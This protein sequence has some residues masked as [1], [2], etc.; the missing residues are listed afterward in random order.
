M[1]ITEYED[2]YEKQETTYISNEE[3]DVLMKGEENLR[4][5]KENE[6]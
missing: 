4:T 1:Y 3:D 2:E 5:I 6:E